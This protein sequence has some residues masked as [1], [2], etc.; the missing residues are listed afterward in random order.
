MSNGNQ[1]PRIDFN[2]VVVDHSETVVYKQAPKKTFVPAYAQQ[3]LKPAAGGNTRTFKGGTTVVTTKAAPV[4]TVGG[5]SINPTKEPRGPHITVTTAAGSAAPK[6]IIQPHSKPQIAP[7]PVAY[8]PED[9][10]YKRKID[11]NAWK[12]QG[13]SDVAAPVLTKAAASAAAPE[14]TVAAPEA[15]AAAPLP[16]SAPVVSQ[17]SSAPMPPASPPLVTG[18]PSSAAAI[19]GGSGETAFGVATGSGDVTGT[20]GGSGAKASAQAPEQLAR[21]TAPAADLGT[22]P[23]TTTTTTTTYTTSV[24]TS[25][26]QQ[27]RAGCCLIL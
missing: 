20:G 7:G 3:Q 5:P 2:N 22:N 24:T 9:R 26:V 13:G 14:A 25:T 1:S 23:T 11:D 12:K 18:Y 17:P 8:V 16:P 19:G 21:G 4:I 10:L 6:R 27:D 15:T